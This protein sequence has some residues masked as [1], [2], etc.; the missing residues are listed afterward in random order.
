M[1]SPAAKKLGVGLRRPCR[2]QTI[3]D[4]LRAMAAAA[5]AAAKAAAGVPGVQV[6]L[7]PELP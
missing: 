5:R 4:V 7:A 3:D 2:G 1:T 6:A